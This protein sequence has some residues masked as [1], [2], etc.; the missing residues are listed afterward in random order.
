[1]NIREEEE[2]AKSKEEEAFKAT[3]LASVEK[4]R[5]YNEQ[6][7]DVLKN[8]AKYVT[9]KNFDEKFE[10]AFSNVTNYN[11]SIDKSG[12]KLQIGSD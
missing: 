8:P 6:F 11:Y 1:M 2:L 5:L 10:F 7:E 12:N 3:Y 9:E 4:I